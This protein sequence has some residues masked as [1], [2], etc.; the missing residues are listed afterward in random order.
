MF[1]IKIYPEKACFLRVSLGTILCSLSYT[2]IPEMLE[3]LRFAT[4]FAHSAV[5]YINEKGARLRL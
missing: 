2:E 1:E 3:L 4:E 5:E